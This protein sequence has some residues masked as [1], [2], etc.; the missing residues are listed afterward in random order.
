[1][2]I[3]EIAEQVHA[4]DWATDWPRKI[5]KSKSTLWD[6]RYTINDAIALRRRPWLT[7]IVVQ[8]TVE[9]ILETILR[10]F[11]NVIHLMFPAP[12]LKF[13]P[14]CLRNVWVGGAVMRFFVS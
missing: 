8:K 10:D 3:I 6:L 14:G 4:K 7:S 2:W 11:L 12:S 5:F 9:A 13:L 1:M